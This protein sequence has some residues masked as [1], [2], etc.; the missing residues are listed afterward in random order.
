MDDPVIVAIIST[1]GSILVAVITIHKPP[2]KTSTMIEV[3][4]KIYNRLIEENLEL[5]EQVKSL[6]EELK[7]IAK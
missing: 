2:L 5:Q 4:Q 3:P 1:L 7:K 6:K